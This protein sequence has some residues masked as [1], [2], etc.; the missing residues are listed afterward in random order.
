MDVTDGDTWTT[1]T[2]ILTKKRY[3]QYKYV[4]LNS[5][6]SLKS[7]ERGVDRICDCDILPAVGGGNQLAG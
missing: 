7:W 2:P 5:D 1:R 6:G 4:I 3:F